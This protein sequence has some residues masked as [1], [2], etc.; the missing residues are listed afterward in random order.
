LLGKLRDVRAL[1]QLARV[2]AE[3]DFGEEAH[4]MLDDDALA[5][6]ARQTLRRRAGGRRSLDGPGRD[7]L[8]RG[9]SHGGAHR[10][11]VSICSPA[12]RLADMGG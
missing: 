11:Q 1:G 8:W 12:G 4:G 6:R 5:L 10:L 9:G 2:A 3:S 7:A